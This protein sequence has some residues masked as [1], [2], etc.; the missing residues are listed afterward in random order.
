[1]APGDGRGYN[2][3]NYFTY[4]SMGKVFKIFLAHLN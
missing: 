1:M 2:K 4:V 3:G